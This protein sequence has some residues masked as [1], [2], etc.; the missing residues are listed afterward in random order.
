MSMVVPASLRFMQA[1]PKVGPSTMKQSRSTPSGRESSS[2]A[3]A[4]RFSMVRSCTSDSLGCQVQSVPLGPEGVDGDALDDRAQLADGRRERI[5]KVRARPWPAD[6]P[7]SREKR[8]VV[9]RF[10]PSESGAHRFER[11]NIRRS[12]SIPQHQ[13]TRIGSSPTACSVSCPDLRGGADLVM[14]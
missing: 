11:R 13:R 3:R 4:R 5:E 14:F 2:R 9:H 1:K 7:L 10:P 6:R 8:Q 12:A